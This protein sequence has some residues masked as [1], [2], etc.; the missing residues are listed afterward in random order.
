MEIYF[1]RWGQ[2]L[3][4]GVLRVCDQIHNRDQAIEYAEDFC[5]HDETIHRI[6]YYLVNDAGNFRLFHTFVNESA[7]PPDGYYKPPPDGVT[8]KIFHAKA[9]WFEIAWREFRALF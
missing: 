3:E 4:D 9:N 8:R 1:C 5:Q 2:R 7:S 6:A